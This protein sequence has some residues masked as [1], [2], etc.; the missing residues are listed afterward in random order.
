MGSMVGEALVDGVCVGDILV[1]PSLIDSGMVN[2]YLT[3]D[4][5]TESESP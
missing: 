5:G 1:S 3:N 2:I 4:G